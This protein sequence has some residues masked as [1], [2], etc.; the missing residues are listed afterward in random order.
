M[1]FTGAKIAR[2]IE[3]A[4]KRQSAEPVSVPFFVQLRKFFVPM[5]GLAAVVAITVL[6]LNP[7]GLPLG[8]DSNTSSGD[9]QNRHPIA[10]KHPA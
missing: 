2:E 5:V 6:S 3:R 1:N 4:E 9:M 8:S 7:A 10:I